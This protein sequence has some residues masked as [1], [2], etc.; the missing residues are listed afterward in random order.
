MALIRLQKLRNPKENFRYWRTFLS[1]TIEAIS[2]YISLY[3]IVILAL[4]SIYISLRMGKG[5]NTSYEYYFKSRS[6]DFKN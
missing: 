5:P 1:E 3:Y 4:Y 2:I 6:Y